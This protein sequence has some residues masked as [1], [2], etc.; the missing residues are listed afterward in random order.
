M[1]P[2]RNAIPTPLALALGVAVGVVL[3]GL[4][5]ATLR[6]QGGDRVGESALVTGPVS[7]DYNAVKKVQVAQEA[8]YYLDYTGARLLAAVPSFQQTVGGAR[9]LG[10]FA[11]RDLVADFQLPKGT[12]PHFLVTTGTLGAFGEPWAPVYV[13]E[14]ST[15]QVAIYRVSELRTGVSTR[16]RFDLLERR[17][18]GRPA[19]PAPAG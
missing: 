17:P 1:S 8:L 18:L 9:V 7:I 6:A 13:L 10:D 2:H 19:P 11:E 15:R 5:P 16:P 14:T 3:S 4:R 12:V